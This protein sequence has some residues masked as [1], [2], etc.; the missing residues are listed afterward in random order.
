MAHINALGAGMFSDLSVA[1]PTADI[2]VATL[3][4]LNTAAGFAALFATEIPAVG[5]TRAA[6]TFVRFPNIREFPS[7][8]TPSNIVNVPRYGSKV[9]AQVQGQA[10]APNLEFTLNYTGDVWAKEVGALLG[11]MVGDG[12][13]R[14]FR[15]ALLKSEPTLT[16]TAK[17]A[18]TA[19]GIGSVQNSHFYFLGK[20]EA[21]LVNPQLTDANQATLT[22][23]AQSDF[24][25]AY[26]V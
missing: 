17:Y 18:S 13:L 10:D 1:H 8:G 24:F 12:I 23:S 15:F 11:L 26:T 21:L 20:V 7:I 6:N 16:T 14:A 25:G 19:A 3:Q 5:G 4:A 2:A 9:S 22:L